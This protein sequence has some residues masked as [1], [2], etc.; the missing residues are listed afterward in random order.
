MS[1]DIKIKTDNYN[2]K[3]RVSGIVIIENKLLVTDMDNSSFFCLPGGY[4]ELG[5]NTEESIIR[6][7]KEEINKNFEVKEYLGVVE[8]Y[9]I[10]KYTK[11]MHEISFY[12]LM[13]P[14]DFIDTNDF[15]IYEKDGEG[16]IKQ[17]FKWIDLNEIDNYDI[18][19]EF[20]K[21]RLRKSDMVFNHLIIDKLEKL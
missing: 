21:E 9:F 15:I 1:Q 12:Y 8:N 20:L 10:N 16:I 14:K 19:P 11:K 17:D 2:F 18:R 7:M 4:V 13:H 6:E 3:F 5:E